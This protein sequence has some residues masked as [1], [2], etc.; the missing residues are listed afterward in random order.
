[1]IKRVELHES[2]VNEVKKYI[3]TNNLEPGDKL[4]NQLKLSELFGV[5]RT[6]LREALRTL[7]AL[8]VVEIIN[9]RGIFVKEKENHIPILNLENKKQSLFHIME[10][11]RAIES[12]AVKL[13]AERAEEDD[14]KEMEKNLVVMLEKA[15]NG[16]NCPEEDK[17]FHFAIYKATKNPLLMNVVNDINDAITVFWENPLGIGLAFNERIN[18]H[19]ELYECIKKKEVK[20][21]ERVFER[22]MDGYEV[23]IKS[24]EEE[25]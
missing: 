5:S 11:R 20:K 3:K 8:N 17:A 15:N 16:E 18:L 24:V 7:Q 13:A 12:L 14:L 21:A 10:V 9:G 19:K 2:I 23:I 22:I 6:S 4:P 1:M 25:L